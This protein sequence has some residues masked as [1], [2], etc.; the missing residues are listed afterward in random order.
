MEIHQNKTA[1]TSATGECGTAGQNAEPQ[2]F[3]SIDAV[4][5]ELQYSGG[6]QRFRAAYNDVTYV[7]ATQA[8]DVGPTKFSEDFV[9]SRECT[10]SEICCGFDAIS[11]CAHEEGDFIQ[12]NCECNFATPIVLDVSDNGYDLTDFR[13]GVQ[14][15]LKGNGKRRQ[16]SWTSAGSDDAFLALD[17]NGNGLIDNGVE[18]FGNHTP[19]RATGPRNGFEALRELDGNGD[20][21]IDGGDTVY[22]ALLLWTDRNHNGESESTELT[23]L[24]ESGIVS[25]ALDYRE[26]KRVDRHGNMFRLRSRVRGEGGP[27]AYDVYLLL[28][29]SA[30]P[31][32]RRPR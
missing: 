3:G 7:P 19:Q 15:D 16:M 29:E 11:A 1:S 24:T 21:A 6:Q 22:P 27:F 30:R 20:G 25:I 12:A 4:L 31:M 2:C 8:C 18:L 10:D 13:G 32:S 14:F 26:S 17:R 28:A 23:S 5:T 9:T